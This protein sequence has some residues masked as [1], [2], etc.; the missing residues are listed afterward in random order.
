L[1]KKILQKRGG[2]TILELVIVIIIVAILAT[3][4]YLWYVSALEKGRKAEAR[5]Q[6]GTFRKLEIAYFNERGFYGNLSDLSTGVPDGN[7]AA[8]HYFVYACNAT[9]GSCTADRCNSGGKSPD[10]AAG[11]DYTV[12]LDINGNFSGTGEWR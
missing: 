2:F 12:T 6:L 4:G 8:T 5:T 1:L 10:I 9:T 7:C 3:L 11:D